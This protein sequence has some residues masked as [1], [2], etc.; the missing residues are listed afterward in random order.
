L[1]DR[2]IKMFLPRRA[3]RSTRAQA[4]VYTDQHAGSIRRGSTVNV[5]NELNELANEG[6]EGE[7][8]VDASR[9]TVKEP[10]GSMSISLPHTE[11]IHFHSHDELIQHTRQI[12]KWKEEDQNYSHEVSC[13]HTPLICTHTRSY[14]TCIY[15]FA[16][17]NMRRIW[18]LLVCPRCFP[19][20]LPL[21]CR[22]YTH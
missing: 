19:P 7:V 6:S 18:I 12:L 22:V 14:V 8:E 1:I 11:S 9:L 2:S 16:V 4:P 17:Y 5:S 10:T 3:V 13:N 15:F 21:W 20:Y